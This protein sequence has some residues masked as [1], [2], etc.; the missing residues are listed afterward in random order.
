MEI[1]Q[2][3][4]V[5][6]LSNNRGQLNNSSLAQVTDKESTQKNRFDTTLIYQT[7]FNSGSLQHK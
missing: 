7:F 3:E 4:S 6:L 2:M 5:I 1:Y